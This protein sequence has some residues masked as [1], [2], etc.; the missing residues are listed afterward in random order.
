M[1]KLYI[2]LIAIFG[3]NTTHAQWVLQNSGTTAFLADVFFTSSNTG[4]AVG[5]N[6]TDSVGVIIKSTDTGTTWATIY[7]LPHKGLSSIY[8]IGENTGYVVGDSGTILKTTNAGNTWIELSSGV[9]DYLWSVFF[10]DTITGYILTYEYY[11]RGKILKTNNGGMTWTL[12]LA[13]STIGFFGIYFTN[14]NTGYVV[15]HT[16]LGEG[17][18][19]KTVDAGTTWTFSSSGRE[20]GYNSVFFANPNIG[21]AVGGS[22]AFAKTIDAGLTWTT[23]EC[24]PALSSSFSDVCFTDVS[25]GYA[26][27][28]T[29]NE[30]GIIYKTNDGGD[31]WSPNFGSGLEGTY[32]NSVFFPCVDTGYVVGTNGTI[33]KTTNGGL[34]VG[35]KNPP[36]FTEYLMIYPNPAS[37]TITIE[38]PSK[39]SL[40][41]LN[42]TGQQLLQQGITEST[43]TLD[44]SGLPSG[45]YVV[46][47]AGEKGMQVGK[48][49]KH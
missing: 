43:T 5:Y 8:F 40:S 22:M 48:F 9:T 17:M 41:I 25:T 16:D 46:K 10:T 15:G 45:I 26:I 38:T 42:F 7:N 36:L 28:M 1:K 33:L 44:V 37:T 11:C 35:I 20:C 49:I 18:F 19:L 32:Y 6:S 24:G 29:T 47:L 39:C 12:S 14:E 21:Y 3:L 30:T 4:Y 27:A 31:S 34:P 2:L 23:N 13:D